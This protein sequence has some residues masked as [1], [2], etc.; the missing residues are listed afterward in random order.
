VQRVST[1]LWFDDQA[2]EVANFYVGVFPDRPT[3]SA[4]ERVQ[5]GNLFPR[6]TNLRRQRPSRRSARGFAAA[7]A[8]EAVGWRQKPGIG[9]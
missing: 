4:S 8:E 1:R 9:S 5:S 2:E 7:E 6:L 3:S